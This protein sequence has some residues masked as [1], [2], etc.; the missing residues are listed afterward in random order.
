MPAVDFEHAAAAGPVTATDATY[1]ATGASVTLAAG[2]W[3]VMGSCSHVNDSG[4]GGVTSSSEVEFRHNS[5]RLAVSRWCSIFGQFRPTSGDLSGGAIGGSAAR[6]FAVIDA[7]ASDTVSLHVRAVDVGS[8]FNDALAGDAVIDAINLDL[9]DEGTDYVYAETANSDTADV[10]ASGTSWV[11]GSAAG[12]IGQGAGEVP[13]T[14]PSDG[15]YYV[16]ARVENFVSG[17]VGSAE[18]ARMRLRLNG[19]TVGSGVEQLV[20]QELGSPAAFIIPL[21]DEAVLSLTEGAEPEIEIEVSNVSGGVAMGYRRFRLLLI[22]LAAFRNYTVSA[23][24]DGLQQVGAGDPES[25]IACTFDYGSGV[26]VFVTA[27]PTWQ[28][29]GGD[30]GSG[31]LHQDSG[32][33]RFPPLGRIDAYNSGRENIGTGGDINCQALHT[34]GTF[35]GSQSFRLGMLTRGGVNHTY[36]RNHANDG[37]A[38]TRIVAFELFTADSG[39]TLTPDAERLRINSAAPTLVLGAVT[40]SPSVERLRIQSAAPSLLLALTLAPASQRFRFNEAEEALVLGAVSLAPASQRMRIQT[41]VPSVLTNFVFAPASER[42][43]FVEGSPTRVLGGVVLTPASQRLRFRTGAVM[44]AT[45]EVG[46][47]TVETGGSMEVFV[48]PTPTFGVVLDVD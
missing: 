19:A 25:S 48:N 44:G 36:G 10:V 30:W 26:D 45:F 23:Q 18:A 11:M 3:V 15:D 40:A 5:T 13:F 46:D 32:D 34:I 42:L 31:R 41:G 2:R 35:T 29:G 20:T 28:S 16:R 12:R 27:A 22:R 8:G 17:T 43:R 6:D 38:N 7:S 9:L 14:V 47:L 4:A 1:V 33:V 21:V 37:D 39:V 24:V